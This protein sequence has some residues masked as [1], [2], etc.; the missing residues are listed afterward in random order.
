M[1]VFHGRLPKEHDHICVEGYH[2]SL[3]P[4]AIASFIASNETAGPS[5]RMDPNSLITDF[6]GSI[7]TSLPCKIT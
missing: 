1:P 5:Y 3:A 6:T 7:R 4:L 2:Q